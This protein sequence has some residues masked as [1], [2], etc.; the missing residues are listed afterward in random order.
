M[1]LSELM[2][3]IRSRNVLGLR[4]YLAVHPNIVDQL[5]G[6]SQFAF[7]QSPLHLA[8]LGRAPE[9]LT[10][11]VKEF[12][13]L[14]D[15]RMQCNHKD[16]FRKNTG[17]FGTKK[18]PD[19]LTALAYAVCAGEVELTRTLLDL[20][21]DDRAMSLVNGIPHLPVDLADDDAIRDVFEA[22]AAKKLSP[23]KSDDDNVLAKI[24][25]QLTMKNGVEQELN[26]AMAI[27]RQIQKKTDEYEREKRVNYEAA[28]WNRRETAEIVKELRAT[29]EEMETESART[30]AGLEKVAA[31]R[32]E[33]YL[34]EVQVLKEV[35]GYRNDEELKKLKKKVK[36]V[37]E[38][39][40]AFKKLGASCGERKSPNH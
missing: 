36:D 32:E 14:A 1:S 40:G 15:A 39:I 6:Q 10:V 31:E 17:L 18:F 28:E 26:T 21:A 5:K 29:I 38:L 37:D 12:G 9:C 24:T 34:I 30:L 22:H 8:I 23:N 16:L 35:H 27:R 33:R 2:V 3:Y 20:G 11:L 13:I 7:C 25:K 19:F 4:F